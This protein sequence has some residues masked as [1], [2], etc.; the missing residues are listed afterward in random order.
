VKEKPKPRWLQFSL[1]TLLALVT[2]AAI[3]AGVVTAWREHRQ[4][5]LRQ[6]QA[7][8]SKVNWVGFY[9]LGIAQGEGEVAAFE[10]DERNRIAS[11]DHERLSRE[12]RRAIWR[13]WLRIGIDDSSAGETP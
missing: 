13:P 7:H 2:L 9:S 1:K 12:Y 6:A 4:F 10:P 3:V 11:E 5:C 8:E